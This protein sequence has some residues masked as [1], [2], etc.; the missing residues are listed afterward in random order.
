MAT[1]PKPGNGPVGD[2]SVTGRLNGL[3]WLAT[4]GEDLPAGVERV[5]V[6]DATD[7]NDLVGSVD[8]LVLFASSI[9]CSTIWRLRYC[10][11]CPF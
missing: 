1:F 4:Y 10:L 7:L 11:S 6:M 5:L 8:I 2:D 9:L 3:K